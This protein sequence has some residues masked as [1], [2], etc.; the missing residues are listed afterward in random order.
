MTYLIEEIQNIIVQPFH[1]YAPSREGA[2]LKEVITLLNYLKNVVINSMKYTGSIPE[3]F[4]IPFFEQNLISDGICGAYVKPTGELIAIPGNYTGYVND[5]G[6]GTDFSGA[7]AIT[8]ISGVPID[9]KQMFVCWNN[10]TR[11][12]DLP[13]L[14]THADILQELNHSIRNLARFAQYNNIFGV[15][16]D[17]TKIAVETAIKK[18]REGEPSVFVSENILEELEGINKVEGVKLFDISQASYFQY[19][20]KMRE[21]ELSF[22]LFLFGLEYG[23]GVKLAQQTEREIMSGNE[24]KLVYVN[25]RL[26]NRKRF[27][28]QLR[29]AGYNISVDLSDEWKVAVE[30]LQEEMEKGDDVNETDTDK[31]DN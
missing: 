25:E 1:R 6:I 9:N 26:K 15:T 27:C 4:N 14:R 3:S 29:Q 19:L 2:L 10:D 20:S 31:R 22:V 12:P 28:E 23:G 18:N 30:K 5:I 8:S 7:T 16:E 24:A 11:T 13:T 17:K 21:D